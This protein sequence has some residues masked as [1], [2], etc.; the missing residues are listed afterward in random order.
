M[1]F[2][3][4]PDTEAP[5]LDGGKAESDGFTQGGCV[6]M[7]DTVL[8]ADSAVREVQP[9]PGDIPIWVGGIVC[10]EP[11]SEQNNKESEV[12]KKNV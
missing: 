1:I 8:V 3:V 6:D 10:V 5:G 9:L 4:S 7:R 12:R 2:T 11:K